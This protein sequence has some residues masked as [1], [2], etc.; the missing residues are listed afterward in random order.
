VT[1][2]LLTDL[3]ELTMAASFARRGMTAPASFSLF[4]RR[5]PANRG[6]LVAHGLGEC[7]EFLQ[8]LRFDDEDLAY[9]STH[10]FDEDMVAGLATIRFDG[11][12]WAVPE[13]H[14]VFAGEPLL[15]VTAPLP[16]A[17]L[18]ETQLLNLMTYR[19]T[20]ASKAARCVLA[21]RGRFELVDFGLRR[22]PGL[23]A[24]LAAARA[25]ALVGFVAT[26]NVEAARLDGTAASGTMA[27]SYI[28]AFPGEA[29]AFRAFAADFPDHTTF[30]VDTYDSMRGVAHAIEVIREL[31]L[32]PAR[33]AVRIDS[34]DLSALAHQAR[35]ALD[36]AG[37]HP[38][39][40]VV[41]GGLDEHGLARLV[42]D[43]APVDAA[44]VGTRM[45]VSNDAPSLD[46][47]YKLV[48][49]DGR[50]V[51]KMSDG[52]ETLPGPKQVFRGD[53][54]HDTL[55]RR[56]EETP[57]GSAPLL[58]PVMEN[59]R[60]L[61]EPGTLDAA[62]ER[63]RADLAQLPAEAAALDHPVAPIPALSPAL[64]ELAQQVRASVLANA[65]PTSGSASARAEPP[66]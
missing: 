47:V 12:V 35:R 46:S 18:V 60:P 14:I 26:S 6:F 65:I 45:A 49:Y 63:F 21:A 57:E 41:S 13:G 10:G 66:G 48:A 58:V 3:Y 32:A 42:R 5:L 17:Q 40:I 9:L 22:A 27:H 7:L 2:A 53:G 52:K 20:V 16:A 56:D 51:A 25:A 4:V 15:E 50:A 44:G 43:G 19:T 11:D 36:D 33:A 1:R 23:E 64:R 29:D 31:G 55:A 59:G 28:E 8:D 30:L 24:G 38:V 62:R 34:G 37:L 61:A 39:R 54:L